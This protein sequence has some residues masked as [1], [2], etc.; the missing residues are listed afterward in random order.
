MKREQI[1]ELIKKHAD[2]VWNKYDNPNQPMADEVDIIKLADAI[3]ALPL[4][5]PSD[6]EIEKYCYKENHGNTRMG[7]K[8]MQEEIIKRNK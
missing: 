2:G 8:W 5:V 1:I 7:A 3:L 4:D 6:D